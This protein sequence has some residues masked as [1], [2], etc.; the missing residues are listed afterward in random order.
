M[1][2][3]GPNGLDAPTEID[4]I[5]ADL[6]MEIQGRIRTYVGLDIDNPSYGVGLYDGLIA[7]AVSVS[8]WQDRIF[9]SFE[10]LG[11]RRSDISVSRAGNALQIRIELGDKVVD[12]GI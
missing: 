9:N 5:D 4:N 12:I 6:W 11:V 10:E 7:E 2:I 1:P 8:E 3:V